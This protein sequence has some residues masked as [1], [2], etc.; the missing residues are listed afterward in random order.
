MKTLAVSWVLGQE[1]EQ[2][3]TGLGTWGVVD[4]F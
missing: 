3:H 1:W 2:L 4:G